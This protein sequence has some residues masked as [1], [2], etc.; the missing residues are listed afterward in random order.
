[1]TLLGLVAEFQSE[2]GFVSVIR[3]LGAS[4]KLQD[5]ALV[6]L[7]CL[8][9][10]I[11]FVSLNPGGRFSLVNLGEKSSGFLFAGAAERVQGRQG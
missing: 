10:E 4:A 7:C 5:S 9:A 11:R 2:A 6:I 3:V 1:M 8:G